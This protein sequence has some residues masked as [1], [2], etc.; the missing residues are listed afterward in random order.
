LLLVADVNKGS[1]GP[2]SGLW[3]WVKQDDILGLG[4]V[5]VGW[6]EGHQP[7]KNQPVLFISKGSVSELM[8]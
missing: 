3:R 4:S 1:I 6:Q 5:V 8:E 2:P 7:V